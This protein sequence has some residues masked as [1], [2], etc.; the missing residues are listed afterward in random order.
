MG[1]TV[2][3]VTQLG[4]KAL[5]KFRGPTLQPV[6]VPYAVLWHPGPCTLSRPQPGLCSMSA[7]RASSEPRLHWDG[8]PVPAHSLCPLLGWHAELGAGTGLVLGKHLSEK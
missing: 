5:V 7:A 8:P 4:H 2:Y 3:Q 1:L 6:R